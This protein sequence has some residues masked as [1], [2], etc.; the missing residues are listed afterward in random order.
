MGWETVEEMET[1]E[2][3]APEA[4]AWETALAMAQEMAKA[5]ALTHISKCR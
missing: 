5:M 1:A 3:M 4:T 2:E